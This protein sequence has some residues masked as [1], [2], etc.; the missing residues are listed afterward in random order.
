M[1]KGAGE[2]YQK[3]TSVVAHNGDIVE[4]VADGHIAVKGHDCQKT[5]ITVAQGVEKIH[6]CQTPSIGDGL[7]F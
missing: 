7:F 5:A 4:G 1:R 2:G 6:L 3:D